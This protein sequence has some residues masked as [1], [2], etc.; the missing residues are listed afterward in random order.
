MASSA[1]GKSQQELPPTKIQCSSCR[2]SLHSS[3]YS[4]QEVHKAWYNNDGAS[5][6]AY[7]KK[8]K[9]KWMQN[10]ANCKICVTTVL[11]KAACGFHAI[12]GGD[13]SSCARNKN[14][15]AANGN[16][17]STIKRDQRNSQLAVSLIMARHKRLGAK[18]SIKAIPIFLLRKILSFAWYD[19]H[20]EAVAASAL[21]LKRHCQEEQQLRTERK[22]NLRSVAQHKK[23]PT[24][25]QTKHLLESMRMRHASECK[26]LSQSSVAA[27]ALSSR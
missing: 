17:E 18:S 25:N 24:M 16:E 15:K 22:R 2:K 10:D 4:T 9:P 19:L 12:Q 11:C 7:T 23:I 1:S 14:V 27:A 8:G 3:A 26:Q 6:T 5:P 20:A 21:M 13:C